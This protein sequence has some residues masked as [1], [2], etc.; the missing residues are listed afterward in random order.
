MKYVVAKI[1]GS[2]YKIEEGQE[3]LVDYLGENEPKAEVLLSV[4][5]ETITIGKPVLEGITL[6]MKVVEPEVKGEKLYIQK[7]KAK[8][9]YRRRTGFRSKHTKIVV[10]GIKESKKK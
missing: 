10:E 7:F 8:S 9:R 4:D 3:L 6:S 1:N 2:Q 5:G